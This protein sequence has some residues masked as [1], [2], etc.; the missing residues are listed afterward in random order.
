MHTPIDSF[1]SIM[2]QDGYVPSPFALLFDIKIK[3]VEVANK[4]YPNYWEDLKKMGFTIYPLTHSN[5]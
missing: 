5:N 3:N 4:S 2:T 1:D